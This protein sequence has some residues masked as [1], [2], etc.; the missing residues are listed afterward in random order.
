MLYGKPYDMVTWGE[1]MYI[2]EKKIIMKVEG[3]FKKRLP[4]LSHWQI[5]QEQKVGTGTPDLL[6]T[7]KDNDKRP[8]RFGRE[9]KD[10]VGKYINLYRR[11]RTT[12]RCCA[13]K[14]IYLFA[15]GGK[16]NEIIS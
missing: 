2:P 4:F 3:E 13:D 16:D 14:S 1:I 12:Q 8:Y 5:K 10:N 15:E 7:A 6:F 11:Q 9:Y